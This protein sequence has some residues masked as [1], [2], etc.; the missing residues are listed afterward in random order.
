MDRFKHTSF[1]S[2]SSLHQEMVECLA[3]CLQKTGGE[4]FAVMLSGGKTPLAIYQAL[5]NRGIKAS[6]SAH[7]LY[8][9]ERDVPTISEENNYHHTVPLLRALAIPETKVMRVHTDQSLEMAASRYDREINQFFIR[10]G[11]VVLGLLG[12]GPDGHTASLF[13]AED[14]DRGLGRYAVAVPHDPK[15]DR[16]SVTPGLLAHV[17]RII[18]LATGPEKREIIEKLMQHPEE[19]VA[20]RALR[21][22]AQVEIWRAY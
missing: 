12:I 10:G 17:D 5:I 7:I 11:R 6:G 1:S 19:V 21:N 13:S 8:S 15:P 4:P 2:L 16:I 18:I 22:A 3:Q 20:G 9:D 14:I